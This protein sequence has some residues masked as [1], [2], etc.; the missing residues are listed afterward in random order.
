MYIEEII[1]GVRHIH[2]YAPLWGDESRSAGL[3]LEFV[4]KIGELEEEDEN[5]LMYDILDIC[6]DKEGNLYVVDNDNT[7]IQVFDNSGKYLKTI[8]RKGQGP[9]EF[10]SPA[11][12]DI[13]RNGVI[14]VFDKWVIGSIHTFTNEGKFQKKIKLDVTLSDVLGMRVMDNNYIILNAQH[15]VPFYSKEGYLMPPNFNEMTPHIKVYDTVGNFIREFCEPMRLDTYKDTQ[16]ASYN[17]FSIDL[18]NNILISFVHQNRIEKYSLNGD[19]IFTMTRA[20]N[21]DVDIPESIEGTHNFKTA[22]TYVSN[23]IDVDYKNRIWTCTF[24]RQPENDGTENSENWKARQDEITTANDMYMFE[25]FTN[26]GELLGR[27]PYN[28]NVRKIRIFN[29]RLFVLD[30]QRISVYEYKIIEK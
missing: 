14:Y 5:Y 7:R 13:D 23:G 18:S 28:G 6:L 26:D 19:C 20:L 4:R 11:Y 8:G 17:Y 27:I 22:P 15:M 25:V 3:A 9:G 30:F 24:S 10:E 1:E 2:N 12:I 16:R 29:D 21:Y